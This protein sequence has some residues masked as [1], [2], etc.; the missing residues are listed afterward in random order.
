MMRVIL[1]ESSAPK[2]D[3]K[4]EKKNGAQHDKCV[5][6]IMKWINYRKPNAVFEQ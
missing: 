6:D 1:I 5:S 3:N 2:A 4:N